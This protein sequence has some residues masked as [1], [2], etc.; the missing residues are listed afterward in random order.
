M[1][2]DSFSIAD[3][4]AHFADLVHQAEAGQ[5]VRITRRGKRVA[6]LLSEAEFEQL[7]GPRGD[8]VPFSKAWRKNMAREGLA[9]VS[10]DE[11]TGLRNQLT[12]AEPDLA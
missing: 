5:I 12:R 8:W 4:K 7:K 9:F 1:F 6:V 3:A 11:L 10:D 2:D